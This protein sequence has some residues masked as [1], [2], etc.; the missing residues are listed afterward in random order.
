MSKG[1]NTLRRR[2]RAA[3]IDEEFIKV[4][5][6]SLPELPPLKSDVPRALAADAEYRLRE[7][8]QRAKSFMVH[9][10]RRRLTVEDISGAFR[11]RDTQPVLGYGAGDLGE[12][13]EFRHVEGSPGLY[14]PREEF[15]KLEDV[16]T[17]ELPARRL[18]PAIEANWIALEGKT[19]TTADED[20]KAPAVPNPLPE[21]YSLLH[22][23]AQ[24]A[25]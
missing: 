10:K 21:R 5:A 3:R 23:F 1:D 24:A 17:A 6:Q 19:V 12:H 11:H 14:V 20:T 18:C 15:V 4:V 7:L 13:I 22:I 8:I 25:G 16:I 2:P 9:S